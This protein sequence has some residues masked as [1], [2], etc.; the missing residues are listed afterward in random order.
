[1]SLSL[2]FQTVTLNADTIIADHLAVGEF[3]IIP[4]SVIDNIG[5]DYHVYYMHTSH[6]SQTMTGLIMLQAEDARYDP[7]YFC[8]LGDN[9]GHNGDASLVPNTRTYL[10]AHP[11]CNVAMSSW[12][13]GVSDNTEEGIDIY[14]NKMQELER[15][16]PDVTF[17]YMT[18]H[19]DGTGPTA[20]FTG[21]ITRFAI[22]ALVEVKYF[23]ILRTLKV[24]I[25][26]ASCIRMKATTVTGAMIGALRTPV[27]PAAHALIR[28]VSTAIG[29]EKPSGG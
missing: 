14:L 3:Y 19:L 18:G 12:C 11:E 15:D 8:Q 1:M 27:P 22:P 25:P 29:R 7:P 23:L 21:A 16:Y 28:T 13:G 4:D 9:L 17:I 2:L 6:G 5:N 26:T 24:M 20:I 10:G